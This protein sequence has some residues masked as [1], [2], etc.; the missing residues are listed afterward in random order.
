MGF[1]CGLVGLPGCGKTTIFNAVTAA[2]AAGYGGPEYN[3]AVVNIP[4]PRLE[5]L[6]TLYQSP[7]QVP[8]IM[9]V[10][11]IPGLKAGSTAGAGRGSRLLAHVKDADALLHVVR[12]FEDA[13]VPFEYDRIDP[14]RDVET[15][16][17]ELMV[18][19]AQTLQNKIDRLTKR[20]RS[21]DKEVRRQLEGCLAIRAALDEGVPARRQPLTPAQ[22]E[23]VA[24]CNLVSLKPV[25]YVANI[26]SSAEARNEHVQALT[27]LAANES[28]EMVTVCGRDE[29]EISQLEPEDQA[30]FLEELGL[31]ESS[32]ERLLRAGYRA[33][34]LIDF[35]TAGPQ[36]I[37]VW[38]VTA[39]TKAPQAAGKI[40]TDLEHG[41]IRMEV[42]RYDDLIELGSDDAV[43]KAGKLRVEGKD[44]VVREG[45]IVFVR[46][47]K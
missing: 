35:I 29:A 6:A 5:P 20:V 39:G 25:L 17:L 21:G 44:Y 16:D 7:K 19:D 34:G 45:D 3:R 38:T 22:R 42:M 31:R 10:V 15:I 26:K 23:S 2:G 43:A 33:L 28:A 30:E 12:C 36:E 14:A 18:A 27:A 13:N 9:E 32:M 1:R 41:F 37:H 8:A 47:N 46:F 11:D 40:H 24:E 4:D